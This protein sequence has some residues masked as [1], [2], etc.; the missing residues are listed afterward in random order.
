M[1]AAADPFSPG[2]KSTAEYST[3]FPFSSI[4]PRKNPLAL[5]RDVLNFPLFLSSKLS[6]ATLAPLLD[7]FSV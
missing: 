3:G 5:A 2:A 6:I 1:N 7:A 4:A